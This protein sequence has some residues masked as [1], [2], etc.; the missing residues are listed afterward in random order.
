MN[1]QEAAA[2]ELHRF[3][4]ELGVPYVIIGGMA[5]Q[6]WGEAR[7]T[8]DVDVTIVPPLDES[9]EI[10]QKIVDRFPARIS[11]AVA[12]AQRNRVI[13]VWA[14]NGC[15]VDISLGLP[16]YED[17]I[18]RRAADY[19]LEAGKRVR[20]C[21]AEDLIIHKAVAGRPQDVRD[22]EGIVYRQRD[23][24]DARYI[25]HWLQSFVDLLANP[26]I[27]ERF[28]RPWRQIHPQR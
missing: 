11:D 12:F 6:R 9:V 23:A 13:L 24:L 1:Q 19:E 16:G 5:V 27:R 22:I 4:T 10:I 7:F 17:G 8:Q 21:S 25:R 15:P 3:L 20:I 26:E 18:M 2:W 28:E 14:S